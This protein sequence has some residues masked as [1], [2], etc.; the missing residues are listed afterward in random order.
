[1]GKGMSLTTSHTNSFKVYDVTNVSDLLDSDGNVV[2]SKAQTGEDITDQCSVVNITG[3]NIDGMTEDEVGK[4]T[5]LIT[6]PDGKH[7]AII[8]WATF[9]GAEGDNVTISNRASFFYNSA[10]QSGSGDKTSDEVVASESSSSLF[11]GPFFYLKKTDQW[12]N[13]V[14]GVTY[15]LYEVSVDNSG[16]ETGKIEVMT[17]TTSDDGTVYFGHRTGDSN[18]QLLKNKLYCLIET[19]APAGYKVDSEPYYFEF[20]EKNHDVI[21]HPSDIE[22][23]QFISGGTYSFTNDFIAA[24]YSVPVQK[25]INGKIINSDTAFSFTLKQTSGDTIYAN[26]SCTTPISADGLK[27]SINGSGKTSFDKMY[28][29][30]TGTYQFTLTEDDLSEIAIKDGYS[31]DNNTFTLTIVVDAGDDNELVIKSAS[32]TSNDASV[33]GG[34]LSNSVPTFNNESHLTG[35]ITLNAK[36]EVTNRTN[37]V[38]AGEFAFTVSVGGEVIAEKNDDGTTKIGSDGKPVKK[39]FYTKDGG[40]IEINIDIDQD[41]V[42]TKTYVIS[43]VEGNDSSIK[44]TTDRVRVKVTIAEAGNGEVKAT[45]YEYLTDAVFTN[46]YNAEGSVKLD[47]T[48]ILKSESTGKAVSMYKGEFNFVVKE[49]DNQ[50]ATGTNESDGSI[51]F[52]DIKYDISDVGVHNYTI[53]EKDEGKL[54]VDYTDKKVQVQVTVTDAGDGKLVTDVQYVDGT[55]DENGHALFTNKYTFVIA[56]GINLDI[57]PYVL[58]IGLAVIIGIIILVRKRKQ[59]ISIN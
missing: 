35:T 44:Y 20:K 49:G 19:N 25:T 11:V 4:P 10:L 52:T 43:E 39:L 33:A 30:K 18:T 23:H 50:V 26:D 21:D 31:K 45:N 7:L 3:Q 22:L 57:L 55:L 37:A 51:K 1:M 14:S 54:F 59:K 58:I 29:A 8:Y 34:N 15:T 9:E 17:Q 47:G 12:G 2:V 42:G 36:K 6:V 24:S 27:A 46:E 48:K 28:F 53:S 5:Y 13:N 40:D 32:F 56:S 41:D 38:K 16:N